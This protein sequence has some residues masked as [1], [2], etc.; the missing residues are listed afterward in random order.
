MGVI[1]IP[2]LRF[3]AVYPIGIFNKDFMS[4]LSSKVLAMKFLRTLYKCK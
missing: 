3:I 2:F 1:S 4:V